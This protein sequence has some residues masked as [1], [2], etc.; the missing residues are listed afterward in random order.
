MVDKSSM[1]L[2]RRY[3]E[4]DLQLDM[5]IDT[6][7]AEV[8]QAGGRVELVGVPQLPV[9]RS[10]AGSMSKAC[11]AGLLHARARDSQFE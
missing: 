3:L 9:L 6:C 10:R 11:A 2:E 7:D 5:Q 1:K 8:D 4:L